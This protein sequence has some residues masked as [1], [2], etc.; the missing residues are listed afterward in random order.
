[1]KAKGAGHFVSEPSRLRHGARSRRGF[2][3]GGQVSEVSDT[4]E[5]RSVGHL[6]S[7]GPWPFP[8][9]R[10]R[11][12]ELR[13][14]FPLAPALLSPAVPSDRPATMRDSPANG[15]KGR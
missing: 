3:E 5:G 15:A 12:V 2:G 9:L 1:M 7:A 11:A 4:F 10:P 6:R 14:K 13:Q 8:H